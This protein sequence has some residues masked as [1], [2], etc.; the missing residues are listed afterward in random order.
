MASITKRR[1]KID[2][3]DAEKVGLVRRS[4]V[5]CI[6]GHV[7]HGKTSLLDALRGSSIAAG[8]AGGITQ[9]ASS[10]R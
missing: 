6:M 2:A 9:R 7:D 4:P 10:P 3:V 8:E 1:G 5:V